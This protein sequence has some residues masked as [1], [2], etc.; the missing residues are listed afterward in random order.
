[1]LLSQHKRFVGWELDSNCV[2][3][4]IQ[5]LVLI[6]TRQGLNEESNTTEE[7]YLYQAASTFV[8]AVEELNRKRR[9]DVWETPARIPIIETFPLHIF[10]HLSTYR[11]KYSLIYQAKTIPT[12]LST[13][14][15]SL[16]LDMYDV[17]YLFAVDCGAFRIRMEA[18]KMHCDSVICGVFSGRLSAAGEIL[19]FYYETLVYLSRT[20]QIQVQ[21]KS[22]LMASYPSL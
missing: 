20:T 14:H 19:R 4:R 21:K 10:Y 22:V 5:L 11:M 18:S 8:K 17:C 3:S 7:R 13:P 9:F 2:A 1:M 12:N 6:F 16:R 15:W